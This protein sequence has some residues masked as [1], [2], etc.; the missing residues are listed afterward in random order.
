MWLEGV[1]IEQGMM[2][3]TRETAGRPQHPRFGAEQNRIAKPPRSGGA[4]IPL[5][6]QPLEQIAFPVGGGAWRARGHAPGAP[7]TKLRFMPSIVD[8]GLSPRN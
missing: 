2:E 4:V 8:P 1:F 6:S 5:A 3:E 7:R